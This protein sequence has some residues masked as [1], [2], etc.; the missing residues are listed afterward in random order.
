MAE[1]T[2][3]VYLSAGESQV[4]RAH[5]ATR[6]LS[7]R[8]VVSSMKPLHQT[9]RAFCT[10]ACRTMSALAAGAMLPGCGGGGNPAGP[11]GG[12]GGATAL[13]V[14]TGTASSGTVS[15]TIDAGSPLASPGS[16]ALVQSGGGSFLVAR[17]AQDAFTVL[18]AT[19]THEACTITGH[20]GQIYVCP[21]HGSQFN[22]SGGVVN[23]P[24]SRPLTSFPATF[25]NNVLSFNV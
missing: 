14:I 4:Q 2:P 11:S 18:T 25:A 6:A 19:C 7:E 22:A 8:I 21:C 12:G 15:V 5:A 20:N 1:R 17:T 13:S 16:A 9:R 3:F 10:Q 24:A 23:G